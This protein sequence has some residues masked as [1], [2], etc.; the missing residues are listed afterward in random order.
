M[1]KKNDPFFNESP[2]PKQ[3]LH[4]FSNYRVL[5]EEEWFALRLAS[6]TGFRNSEPSFIKKARSRITSAEMARDHLIENGFSPVFDSFEFEGMLLKG[7]R[8]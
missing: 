3:S 8:V 1:K 5:E 2:I 4:A 6:T 7:A